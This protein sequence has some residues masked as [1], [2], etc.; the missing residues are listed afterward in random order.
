MGCLDSIQ[1]LQ[2]EERWDHSRSGT[3][4]N[5]NRPTWTRTFVCLAQTDVERMPSVKENIVL[6]GALLGEKRLTFF[7]DDDCHVFY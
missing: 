7:A 5:K 2:T 1:H 4:K 6:K 3:K